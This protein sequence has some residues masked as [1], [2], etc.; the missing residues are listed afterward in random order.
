MDN[1]IQFAYIVSAAL[2]I[3]GLKQLGSPAT[4]R[5]GNMISSSGMLLAIVAALLDQGI[6]SYQMMQAGAIVVGSPTINNQMFPTVADFL[7]YMKGLKPPNKI[8]AA[9]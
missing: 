2:F 4:A 7:C 6:V 5:R 9:F 8:A 1:L 3:F